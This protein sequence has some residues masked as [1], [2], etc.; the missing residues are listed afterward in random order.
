VEGNIEAIVE[1]AQSRGLTVYV[2]TYYT[3]REAVAPC[4]ALF[5]DTIIP[6]QASNANDYIALLNQRIRQATQDTGAI[7]VDVA[8]LDDELRTTSAN[9]FDCNHLST[10]GNT[11]VAEL[12]ADII[13]S[14]SQP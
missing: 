2:A 12:F 10:Q 13:T 8:T 5:L 14:Q 4:D 9:Y 7:L 11:L 3:S 1:E 6:S